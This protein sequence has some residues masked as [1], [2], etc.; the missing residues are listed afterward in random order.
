MFE[1]YA[2]DYDRWFDDH[3]DAYLAELARIR[4]ALPPQDSLSLEV[5]VGSGR[6]AAPLGV[7]LGIDPSLALCRI[8][9]KRGIE[10]VRGTAEALPFR[11]ESCS[12]VLMV[13]VIC[14]LDNPLLALREIQRILVP[15]G[16]LIIG[17]LER[18]GQ[19]ARKYLQEEGKH[20]FLSLAR[21]SSTDEI[22]ESLCTAGFGILHVD[23]HAGFCMIT[24]Q[25]AE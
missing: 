10:I 20:R 21:F 8:A 13:T 15:E 12:S 4:R 24:A 5:G 1:D 25:K 7:G 16:T 23:S 22:I 17:F 18:E 9:R 2:E 14:F 6:F 3:H 11:D 19:I